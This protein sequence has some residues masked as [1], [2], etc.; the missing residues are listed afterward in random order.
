MM[1]DLNQYIPI[2]KNKAKKLKMT[3]IDDIVISPLKNKKYRI[4]FKDGTNVDYGSFG[5]NDFLITNDKKRKELFHQRF[6]N[7]KGYNNY[8][9]G[10]YYSS[11][12]L[13]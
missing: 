7:N 2:Q 1:I 5:M 12:L 8:N 13:W 6:K 4:I 10:L 11:R 9:S 3:W